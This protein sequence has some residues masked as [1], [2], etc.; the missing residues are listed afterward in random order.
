MLPLIS[1]ILI[2][3][4]IF[5]IEASTSRLSFEITCLFRLFFF[6]NRLVQIMTPVIGKV[7]RGKQAIHAFIFKGSPKIEPTCIGLKVERTR[8]LNF[9]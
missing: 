3:I 7:P 1:L 4:V 9:Y 2:I 5:L 6:S 8:S